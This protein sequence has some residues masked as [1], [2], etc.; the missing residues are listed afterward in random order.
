MK[1]YNLQLKKE[2]LIG[3]FKFRDLTAIDNVKIDAFTYLVL[4]LAKYFKKITKVEIHRICGFNFKFIEKELEKYCRDQYLELDLNF[5]GKTFNNNLNKLK[6]IIKR[7][8]PSKECKTSENQEFLKQYKLTKLGKEILHKKAHKKR[9]FRNFSMYFIAEPFIFLSKKY[10]NSLKLRNRSQSLI[11]MKN[12]LYLVSILHKYLNSSEYLP[13]DLSHAD[14]VKK[15]EESTG[16]NAVWGGKLTKQFKNWKKNQKFGEN[17][18]ELK[19][20]KKSDIFGYVYKHFIN[21]RALV[22]KKYT[23][24]NEVRDFQIEINGKTLNLGVFKTLADFFGNKMQSIEYLKDSNWINENQ[25][26]IIEELTINKNMLWSLNLSN[27]NKKPQKFIEDNFIKNSN[28][29]KIDLIFK[30]KNEEIELVLPTFIYSEKTNKMISMSSIIFLNYLKI[31][32][33]K[34]K[35]NSRKFRDLNFYQKLWKECIKNL[36]DTVLNDKLPN[37]NKIIEHLMKQNKQNMERYENRIKIE[38]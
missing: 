25:R 19:I 1:Y 7:P 22:P 38:I 35:N 37:I 2:L 32:N 18:G 26:Q 6:S 9:Y 17:S 21:I 29:F 34:K 28:S 12:K 5:D 8:N 13:E 27:L 33:Q 11:S 16:K 3:N 15:F 31:H 24:F 4:K 14:L 30:V 10:F 20:G 36:K 23:N